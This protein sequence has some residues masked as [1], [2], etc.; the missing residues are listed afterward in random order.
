MVK[1]LP[2]LHFYRF[3]RYFVFSRVN[4]VSQDYELLRGVCERINAS[5]GYKTVRDGVR[6]RLVGFISLRGPPTIAD[7]I[8]RLLPNFLVTKLGCKHVDGF[9]WMAEVAS[10]DGSL[11][12]DGVVTH[13]YKEHPFKT[14]KTRLFLN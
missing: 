4:P 13:H 2:P 10:D 14:V 7:D 5:L 1:L 3:T 11:L 12:V 8:G 9:H 6:I